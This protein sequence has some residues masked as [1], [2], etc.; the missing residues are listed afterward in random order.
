MCKSARP[1]VAAHVD[2]RAEQ[3]V[4]GEHVPQR[5][6]GAGK[7]DHRVERADDVDDALGRGVEAFGVLRDLHHL[8]GD[9]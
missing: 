8:V 4:P 2:P 1:G 6:P 9:R 7:H 3:S 5:E